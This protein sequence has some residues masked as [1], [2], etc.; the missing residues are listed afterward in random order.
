MAGFSTTWLRARAK[1]VGSHATTAFFAF[2]V[3]FVLFVRAFFL[4]FVVFFVKVFLGAVAG[5]VDRPL[6]ARTTRSRPRRLAW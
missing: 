1:R 4:V 3:F 6:L 2:V 5:V